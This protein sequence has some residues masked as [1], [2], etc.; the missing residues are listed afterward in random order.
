[1]KANKP[2]R[3]FRTP[4]RKIRDAVFAKWVGKKIKES[5]KKS[6]LS[7]EEFAEQVLDVSI[8]SYIQMTSG[9]RGLSEGR[10]HEIC[11]KMGLKYEI[12]IN[13]EKFIYET[14]K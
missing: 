11:E 4:K 7:P 8:F 2:G 13:D 14:D 9:Q 6:G 1:M 12:F 3:Q 10:V 5:R